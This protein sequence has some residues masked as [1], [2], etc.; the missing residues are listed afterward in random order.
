MSQTVLIT[1]ASG[2]LGLEFAKIFSREGY[3]L[4]IVARREGM[5]FRA[6]RGRKH[7]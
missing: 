5:W 6:D 3:N 2:G 7:P 4:L 1:G